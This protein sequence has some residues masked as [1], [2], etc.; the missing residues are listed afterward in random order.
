MTG[1]IPQNPVKKNFKIPRH[2]F[3]KIRVQRYNS[4]RYKK[5]VVQNIMIKFNVMFRDEVV[6]YVEIN[7]NNLIKVETYSNVVYK[8]PFIKKPVTLEYVKAFLQKR[9]VSPD[10]TNIDEILKQL[11]IPKYDI[12]EILK[13]THGTNFDDFIWIKFIGEDVSWDEVKLR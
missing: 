10:K 8:Q 3:V 4:Y 13:K 2:R 1:C 9:V 5:K 7:N 12:I 11:E 6:A